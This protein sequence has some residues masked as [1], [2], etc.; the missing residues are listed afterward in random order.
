MHIVVPVE[1][2][3]QHFFHFPTNLLISVT[4]SFSHVFFFFYNA[5]QHFS[6]P[7]PPGARASLQRPCAGGY[8]GRA[9]T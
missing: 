5:K 3:P 1:V 7:V 8:R 9:G 6:V 4:F 2:R